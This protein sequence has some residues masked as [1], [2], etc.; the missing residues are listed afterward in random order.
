MW[1]YNIKNKANIPRALCW[2]DIDPYLMLLEKKYKPKTTS[3]SKKCSRCGENNT[4]YIG[5]IWVI[6][7]PQQ[8]PCFI[9]S[10][11]HIY[12]R[13]NSTK[14]KFVSNQALR[15]I[16]QPPAE[17]AG[18]QTYE[19]TPYNIHPKTSS[20]VLLFQLYVENLKCLIGPLYFNEK[21]EWDNSQHSRFN[22][23]EL[24]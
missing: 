22:V 1:Y 13:K 12:Y 6:K 8:H 15:E 14:T 24:M 10:S 4:A 20:F 21:F 17:T 23:P 5:C 9:I 16:T 7:R 2:I 18:T 3:E 11:K 19:A